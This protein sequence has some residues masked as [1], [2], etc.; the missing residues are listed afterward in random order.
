MVVRRVVSQL[1]DAKAGPPSLSRG[2]GGLWPVPSKAR[3][4]NWSP[5]ARAFRVQ[6][7]HGYGRST[8]ISDPRKPSSI[9]S[10]PGR[11]G[12]ATEL[13]PMARRH[14]GSGREKLLAAAL[15]MNSN[16]CSSAL[17]FSAIL[18]KGRSRGAAAAA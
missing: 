10:T 5:E 16:R 17:D 14:G 12:G 6:A 1:H 7:Y 4:S 3:T 9:A 2:G 8:R 15:R 18:S 13:T 11:C